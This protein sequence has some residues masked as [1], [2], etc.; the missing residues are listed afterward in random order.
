MGKMTK[1]PFFGYGERTNELLVSV[2][3]DVCGPMT[4]QARGGYSNFITFMEDLS[5]FGYVYPMKH[6]FKA[7]DR[8]K[9]YQ[10]MVEK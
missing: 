8:F 3:I 7:F 9:E 2:H 1:T 10:R 6:K 5:R 4:T